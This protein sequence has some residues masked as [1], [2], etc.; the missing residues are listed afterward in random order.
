MPFKKRLQVVMR[1]SGEQIECT[2]AVLAPRWVKFSKYLI[3]N[4]F[5]PKLQSVLAPIQVGLQRQVH[6][7]GP[8]FCKEYM[9]R[10]IRRMTF[11]FIFLMG[12]MGIFLW[13]GLLWSCES[14]IN[15][16][17]GDF[18]ALLH[19]WRQIWLQS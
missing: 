4:H 3:I 18:F 13:G 9:P 5:G 17:S 6:H 1:K 16:F 15:L 2:G 19:V 12:F 11:I 8:S 7:F 10:W 14:N